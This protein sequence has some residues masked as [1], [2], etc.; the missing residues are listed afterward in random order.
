MQTILPQLPEVGKTYVSQID[1]TLSIYVEEIMT[2]QKD[3]FGDAG[4]WVSCCHPEDKDKKDAPGYEFVDDEW[5]SF[6]FVQ[7]A[8]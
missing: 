2:V 6:H 1:P 8:A 3:E 7:A 5:A 4:F